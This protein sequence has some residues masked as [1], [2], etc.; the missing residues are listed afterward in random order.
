MTKSIETFIVNYFDEMGN[1]YDKEYQSLK[2]AI[3]GLKHYKTCY[4]L[5]YSFNN[6]MAEPSLYHPNGSGMEWS[7]DK[8]DWI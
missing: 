6:L 4:E 2:D 3:N 1:D 5:E 7:L 8:S